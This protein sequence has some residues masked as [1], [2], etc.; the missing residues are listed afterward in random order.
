MHSPRSGNRQEEIILN[1]AS[2]Q[3][4]QNSATQQQ[5]LSSALES[6][7]GD[8]SA[9]SGAGERTPHSELRDEY[10]IYSSCDTIIEFQH[11]T[12]PEQEEIC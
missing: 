11:F 1:P 8:W 12:G 10:G 2:Y 5:Q 4:W 7:A 9:E 6:H 3:A